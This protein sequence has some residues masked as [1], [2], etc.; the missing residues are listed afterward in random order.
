MYFRNMHMSFSFLSFFFLFVRWVCQFCLKV[1]SPASHISSQR[2][3]PILHSTKNERQNHPNVFTS[4][5]GHCV[6]TDM[7][8]NKCQKNGCTS[9]PLVWFYCLLFPVSVW[10]VWFRWVSKVNALEVLA[11]RVMFLEGSGVF[12]MWSLVGNI[13]VIRSNPLK[14][15]VKPWSASSLLLPESQYHW[16]ARP[17]T[18]LTECYH[19]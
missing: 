17:Q 3:F 16:C 5:L 1:V 2:S 11:L 13:W 9:C 12:R 18:L 7:F 4:G 8:S 10:I 19:Q 15:A 14:E 6:Q